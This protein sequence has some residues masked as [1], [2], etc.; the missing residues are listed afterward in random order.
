MV[1]QLHRV[2]AIA[3]ESAI[4]DFLKIL[5]RSIEPRAV[6]IDKLP[7]PPAACPCLC[8]AINWLNSGVWSLGDTSSSRCGGEAVIHW[9]GGDDDLG[10]EI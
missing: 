9:G 2:N 7:L 1:L 10:K 8:V 6:A 5:S 4:S 3:D